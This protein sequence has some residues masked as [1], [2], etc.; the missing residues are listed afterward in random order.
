MKIQKFNGGLATRLEPHFINA[1]QSTVNVNVDT[2]VGV[3]APVKDKVFEAGS[4]NK[5]FKYFREED[6]IVTSEVPSDFIEFQNFMIVSDRT[7]RPTKLRNGMKSFLGIERPVVAPT[8]SNASS[9]ESLSFVT[10][11][12]KL[13]IDYEGEGPIQTGDLPVTE[14]KYMLFKRRNGRLSSGYEVDVT[15]V[16]SGIR[17]SFVGRRLSID[18]QFYPGLYVSTLATAERII[19]IDNFNVEAGSEFVVYRLYE[20]KWYEVASSANNFPIRDFRYDISSNTEL[21][22]R[23]VTNFN[24]TYQYV[25]TYYNSKDGVES[26]PSD[27]SAEL[28]VDSGNIGLSNMSV[29][30][31][32]QVDKKRIYRV[33]NNLATFTLVQEVDNSVSS[34]IDD[35]SDIA[36]DGRTLQSDNYF[37]APA[38]LKY[39]TE[40]Y[41]MLFGVIDN[42]LR[43]TPIGQPNAWPPE[44]SIPYD[45]NITGIGSTA[46]GVLVMT[47]DKTH[48]VTGTG[49][50]SLSSQSLRGDQG[51]ISHDSIQQVENGAIV[52]ASSDGLC[53]S[54]GGSPKNITKYQL[55]DLKFDPTSSSVNNE[56]YYLHN[57]DG[58]IFVWDYRF[59]PVFKQLSLGVEYIQ[60]MRDEMFGY[61]EGIIY[62][63]LA[64]EDYLE[65]SYFSP[66]FIEGSYTEVRTYNKIYV[67]TEGQ[68]NLKIYINSELV[69]EKDF[70]EPGVK[71]IK[72]PQECQRGQYLEFE[73]SGTGKFYELEYMAGPRHND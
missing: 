2:S 34:F 8:L 49:P 64:S 62:K 67:Y 57:N 51:C 37:E 36:V 33:G 39:L 69:I 21:D 3:L 29:S 22:E 24:G 6:T 59:E 48:L 11:T 7:N 41:A 9:S 44:F 10:F 70:E 58:I 5:Y 73:V 32:P 12:A 4:Q 13:A 52:W 15:P 47:A 19:E 16:S 26:A 53:V 20:G 45:S 31:D 23:L 30:A 17:S 50:F 18:E 42:T 38:G 46:N 1:D 71:Q 54:A 66:R 14:L 65:L 63:L 40:A 43:F 68:I 25:Y 56:V 60:E 55:G 28:E 27:L 35:I 72:I 61:S